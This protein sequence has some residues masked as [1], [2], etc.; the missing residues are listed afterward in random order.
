M[1]RQEEEAEYGIES[2]R[3]IMRLAWADML[4]MGVESLHLVAEKVRWRPFYV[5][6][7]HAIATSIGVNCLAPMENPSAHVVPR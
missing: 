5:Q 1:V 7:V 3:R 4:W 6:L 2:A